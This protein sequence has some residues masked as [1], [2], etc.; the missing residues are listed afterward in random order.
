MAKYCLECNTKL[1]LFKFPVK[2]KDG[3]VCNSCAKKYDFP[4]VSEITI[5]MQINAK[6]VTWEHYK[7][8]PE[9][10]K[11]WKQEAQERKAE[12]EARKEEARL[13]KEEKNR[14]RCPKCGSTNIQVL[15]KQKKGFSASKAVGGALLTGGVGTLAGFAGK[16][17]KKVEFVCMSCGRKFKK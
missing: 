11:E 3:S 13:A 7:S 2:F 15:G 14:L 12:I 9:L 6:S 4:G 8:H 5:E 16:D 17:G 1:N 10:I